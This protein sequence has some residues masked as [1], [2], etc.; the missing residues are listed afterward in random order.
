[1]IELYTHNTPSGHKISIVLEELGLPYVVKRVNTFVGEQFSPEFLAL[2]PNA[3]IP[4]IVDTEMGQ[5][6]YESN[7]I[8][9]YL[10]EKTGQLMPTDLN[11]RYEALELLFLHAASVGPMFGQREF[12]AYFSSEESAVRPRSVQQRSGPSRSCHG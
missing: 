8:F 4:V 2:N 9:L 5:T 11:G 3:K 1:M 10:A 7:A 6:V 12:Y